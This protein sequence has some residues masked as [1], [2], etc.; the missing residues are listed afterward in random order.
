M[1]VRTGRLHA[2]L[3]AL[4]ELLGKLRAQTP[5][6]RAVP[7]DRL[8]A[9]AA[10]SRFHL[11]PG[12]HSPVIVILGGT[13]TGKSTLVNRLIDSDVTATSFR[14]TYTAGPVAVARDRDSVPQGWMGLEPI[15]A[16]AKELPARGQTD[17]LIVVPL[18]S[19]LAK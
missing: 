15:V 14:R 3:E 2:G 13:G 11:R 19:E 16:G 17:A 9:D 8:R 4:D 6:L 12:D 1:A 18:N 10:A 5:A 7:I